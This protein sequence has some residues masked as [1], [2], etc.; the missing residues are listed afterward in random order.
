MA[1]DEKKV[2]GPSAPKEGTK[3]AQKS[4]AYTKM[5][6]LGA[7]ILVTNEKPAAKPAAKKRSVGGIVDAKA[8]GTTIKPK[9]GAMAEK[10][11]VKKEA[12]KEMSA[13]QEAKV[14]RIVQKK[15][16]LSAKKEAAAKSGDKT[17]S[18]RLQERID[19][20][21]KRVKRVSK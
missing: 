5:K 16:K 14:S 3:K 17:R 1:V 4:D 2:Y 15:E 21:D 8:K 20:K 11:S 13:K 7:G 18:A 10:P 19:R 12:K 9:A 6:K